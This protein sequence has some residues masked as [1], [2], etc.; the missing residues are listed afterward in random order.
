MAHAQ[1]QKHFWVENSP[2]FKSISF[3][4]TSSSGTCYLGPGDSEDA[5]SVLSSRDIDDFN[6]SFTHDV[7]GKEMDVTLKLEEKN[8]ESFSQSI[9]SKMF[10]KPRSEESIWKVFLTDGS[11]V[12]LDLT[13]GIG[14]AYID[15]SGLSV[16]SLVVQTGSAD[17]NIGYLSGMSNQ[18]EME[19]FD[20]KVDLGN[21]D[22]KQLYMTRARNVH[23]D[24]GF[25][26]LVLDMTEGMDMPCH[27]TA[28]VGA[29]SLEVLI[30][31]AGTPVMIRIKKSLLCDVRLTKSFR[32]LKK[33][34][35]VNMEYEPDVHDLLQFDVDVSLGNIV[36]KEKK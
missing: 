4:F 13:Y 21:I 18:V 36:F 30:P 34:V 5:V 20:V 16:T 24:I 28:S 11:P 25:G 12:A 15:L 1:I 31:K 17:V 33:D 14:Q 8:E 27:V 6:H 7:H 23:A 32:E 22:V 2:E 9:S 19:S 35:F 29:G 10:S 3:N 26:D